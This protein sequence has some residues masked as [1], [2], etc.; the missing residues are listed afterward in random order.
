VTV[1]DSLIAIV[2]LFVIAGGGI[3]VIDYFVLR[4]IRN[5]PKA[6]IEPEPQDPDDQPR[7]P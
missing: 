3:I 1:T 6:D 2:G 4:R 5:Q 7:D